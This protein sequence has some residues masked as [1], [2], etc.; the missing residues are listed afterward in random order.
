MIW[1]WASHDRR[2]FWNWSIPELSHEEVSW[3][4]SMDADKLV[5]SGS[6]R[7]DVVVCGLRSIANVGLLYNSQ[8]EAY[9]GR[10]RSVLTLINLH[11]LGHFIKMN[12]LQYIKSSGYLLPSIWSTNERMFR[13]D[14]NDTSVTTAW[15]R[16]FHALRY[17]I[18]GQLKAN[19]QDSTSTPCWNA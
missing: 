16:K 13:S 11:G 9:C 14:A 15:F 1:I 5:G 10:W 19:D 12:L 4:V 8:H 7:I 2:W 17:L 18:V 6:R 3:D